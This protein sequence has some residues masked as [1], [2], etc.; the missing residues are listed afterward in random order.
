MLLVSKG[1]SADRKE[2][3][4]KPRSRSCKHGEFELYVSSAVTSAPPSFCREWMNDQQSS[5]AAIELRAYP[6][7]CI[8]AQNDDNV[9]MNRQSISDKDILF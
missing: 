1:F 5:K 4:Q 3:K 2:E 6:E 9:T 8:T 7:A